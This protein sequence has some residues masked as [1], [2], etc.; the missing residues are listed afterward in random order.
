MLQDCRHVNHKKE[1]KLSAYTYVTLIEG[2][3]VGGGKTSSCRL[4]VDENFLLPNEE[5]YG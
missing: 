5:L 1:E 2:A 4:V 3:S